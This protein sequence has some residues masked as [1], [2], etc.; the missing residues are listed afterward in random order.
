[1]TKRIFLL[2]LAFSLLFVEST[3]FCCICF[4]RTSVYPFTGWTGEE[5]TKRDFVFCTV[6]A[7]ANLPTYGKFPSPC[8]FVLHL[9]GFCPSAA[10]LVSNQ[11]VET[12]QSLWPPTQRHRRVHSTA[13]KTKHR[14]QKRLSSSTFHF[15]FMFFYV[16]SGV[17]QFIHHMCHVQQGADRQCWDDAMQWRQLHRHS[18]LF[19]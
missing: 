16:S 13:G 10:I 7:A 3:P 11:V 1:M 18:M 4:S 12:A 19:W 5:T 17:L 14:E 2:F 15:H 6:S 8:L 9:C